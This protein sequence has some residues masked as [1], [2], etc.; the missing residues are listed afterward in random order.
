M[1]SEATLLLVV[2][3]PVESEPIPVDV[4]VDSEAIELFAELR[5][6]EVE[7]ESEVIELV[8]DD[9]PVD[10]DEIELEAESS[11]DATA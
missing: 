1:D 5:P 4:E 2:D 7:V 3:R 6:V 8:A 11:F 10:S 9:S